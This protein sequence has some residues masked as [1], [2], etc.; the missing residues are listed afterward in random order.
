MKKVIFLILILALM[1]TFVAC[2]ANINGGTASPLPT[3][4]PHATAPVSP[5]PTGGD[6]FRGNGNNGANGAIG[7]NNNNDLRSS[8]NGT[9]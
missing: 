7:G 5:S 4:S 6:I 8:P 3:V 9:M 2:R 1:F